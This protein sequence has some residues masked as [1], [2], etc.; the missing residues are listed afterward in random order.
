[1]ANEIVSWDETEKL[2]KEL[3]EKIKA[4]GFQPTII[5]PVPRGGWCVAAILAQIFDLRKT[6]GITHERKYE[7]TK[8]TFSI[9]D[10][11]GENI[12]LIEDSIETGKTFYT[13]E[14]QLIELGAN[15]KTACLY[16]CSKSKQVKYPD[17]YLE[18]RELPNFVWDL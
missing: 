8:A 18:K 10:I 15:I 7:K 4:S 17:F 2:I 14:K 12:L 5:A 9:N 3:A 16:V 13:I 6:L 1:M 11:R